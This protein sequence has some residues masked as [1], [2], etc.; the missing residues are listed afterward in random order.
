MPN[1]IS[2]SWIKS[3]SSSFLKNRCPLSQ[4]LT[5][6]SSPRRR[7]RDPR[8]ARR[9]DQPALRPQHLHC[10]ETHWRQLRLAGKEE[11]VA[12]V[13]E[14]CWCFVKRSY[15]TFISARLF[16]SASMSHIAR[17]WCKILKH[18]YD[19]LPHDRSTC[20]SGLSAID[21]LGVLV[22]TWNH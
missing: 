22:V 6:L 17:Y 11:R 14:R 8:R 15:V 7:C 3:V 20:G 16:M 1:P 2:L 21:M 10:E 9:D 5:P 12:G 13:I 19:T 4:P 18:G